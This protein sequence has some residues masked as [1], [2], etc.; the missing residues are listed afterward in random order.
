MRLITFGLRGQSE[1]V[2]ALWF[3]I[4]NNP[5]RCR[6]TLATALQRKEQP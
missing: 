5:K 4:I 6:A 2:T 3:E 1:A